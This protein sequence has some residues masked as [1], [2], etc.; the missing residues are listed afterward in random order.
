MIRHM[1]RGTVAA[2]LLGTSMLAAAAV[3][4]MPALAQSAP[5]ASGAG[6]A[7]SEQIVVIGTRRTD[8]SA[9]NSA[10]P[11]DVISAQEIT[12][13]P[14]AN[15]LDAVK[16]IIPS[17]FVGQNTISDAS[18][19]VRA[20]S[21][22]GLPGDEVLVM[23]NGKRYN[24]SALVQVFVGGDTG[25]SFGSQGSDISAIPAIAI[26]NLQV[27]RDG[28]TAQ[29]G[30]DAIAGVLN[31]GLREDAGLEIQARYGQYYDNGGDGK[32]RQIAANAGVKLGEI[33]FINLS[34]EYFDDNGTSRGETRPIALVFAQNNPSLATQLPNYPGPVQI[35]G[36][37]PSKG[38][39]LLLNSGLDVTDNSNLY[40]FVNVAHS[41]GDQSFN[42]RSP[43]SATG[44]QIDNGATTTLTD[45]GANSAFAHPI[46]LTQCPAGNAS[47]PA[48][49]FVKDGNVYNFT[50][51]Y[52]AGF[53]PR[54]IGIT[55]QAYGT[56]GYKGKAD[57]G[58][59][60]DIAA[61]LAR[62]SLDLSMYNSLSPSFGPQTQTEFEFGKL[63][64]KEFT[65]TLD[66]TY[67]VELAGLASPVTLAF[68]AEYR[69]E[70]YEQ[71]EGDLQSYA[72]GPYAVQNLYVPTGPGTY[73]FDS[74]VTM[75]PAASGY[76]GTSPQAAGS[77]SQK[78]YGFYGA[79][80][81]DITD[82]LTVGVAGRYEHYD[83][84][85]SAT[86]GKA[87]AIY[88][89]SDGLSLRG[90]V[91][92]G[93]HAP[94]PGQNSVQ[95]LTTNFR[96]GNQVQTGTY[97][98]TSQIAQFYGG[99]PLKPA[100]ATNFGLGVVLNPA[101]AFT[102]TVDG[103]IIKVRDRIGISQT[104]SVTAA[105]I[106]ALP[107]LAAV[108]AGGDVNYFTNAFDT[109]TRGV[110]VVGTYRTDL[111]GGKLNL[112]LAYN[113]NKSKVSNYDPAVIGADQIVNVAHLAPN[114][115]ANLAANWT[116]GDFTI[117][118]REN[119]HSWW[120]VETDYPGQRFSSKFTTD[121]DVSYTFQDRYTLTVGANNLFNTYPERITAS[122]TNPIFLST[123]SLADGQVYP[124]NGGP[125]GI[126]GGF[127][128]AR[129]RVKY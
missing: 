101:P 10:S 49:G 12:S 54:F 50:A 119:Y 57:S 82:R 88:K 104:F 7:D 114:H 79:A 41:K 71:T 77:Y 24:R 121:L 70:T 58:F 80:E 81:T 124:R 117:N 22:R 127:W 67:P 53:T 47:C 108:G 106:A 123:N 125:F 27:L 56:L 29:Y 93:F 66:L 96:A 60:W 109:I 5:P 45:L 6:T 72:A 23:L 107:A 59:T 38:Y 76:G 51:L 110:D 111:A 32:S 65:A 85:G 36:S 63:I 46:Y 39:K 44:L 86:V 30:S 8:R 16:N 105:D 61:S 84:F 11:V 13:Q 115:R 33:G 4:G 120:Q 40:L 15:M 34:G 99:Q 78:S 55:D 48:G 68:G 25:L 62:N 92:T 91:G 21:L 122:A 95:I 9:T 64:Q 73:A 17:F 19:F 102:L 75:P 42:Y 112:T 3:S 103:Y 94:S 100:K 98:V 118:A 2:R 1:T 26:N 113:Y 74:T 28:A 35:W 89:F 126:N 128:Y 83:S 18:T 69:K 129:L 87:N 90:T 43:I 14:A 52:P 20:P 116:I 31:Y 37:S 97:P